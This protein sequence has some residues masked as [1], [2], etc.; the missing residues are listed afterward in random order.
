VVGDGAV[1]YCRSGNSDPWNKASYASL[2]DCEADAGQYAA[3][4]AGD[5]NT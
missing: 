1:T 5:T 4:Q 2:V 3:G